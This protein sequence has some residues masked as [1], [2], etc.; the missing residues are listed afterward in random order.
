MT[1]DTDL[2]YNYVTRHMYNII[3]EKYAELVNKLAEFEDGVRAYD[4]YIRN[5][6][7]DYENRL[8]INTDNALLEIKNLFET[9]LYKEETVLDTLRRIDKE[10]KSYTTNIFQQE[11]SEY[12]Q[13]MFRIRNIFRR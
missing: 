12:T 4:S 6:L 11:P 9:L 5:F 10:F 2:A 13:K 8:E 1:T 7:I 3:E